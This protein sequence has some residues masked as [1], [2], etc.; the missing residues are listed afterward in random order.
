MHLIFMRKKNK[1]SLAIGVV[2]CNDK[3]DVLLVQEKK[4]KEYEKAKGYWGI[5][6]GKVKWDESIIQGLKREMME[7]LNISVI[8]M[9]L[10]G[11]YQYIRD[12]SQC[13]GLAFVIKNICQKKIKLNFDELFDYKWCNPSDLIKSRTLNL[14]EGTKEVILDFLK[15]ET[16]PIENIH[17]L[18]LRKD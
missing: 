4:N 9:G 13:I 12:N 6:T 16:I 17:L 8:P 1:P 10:I 3:G 2:F 14:R 15:A 18:D 5:P 11:V 7:E